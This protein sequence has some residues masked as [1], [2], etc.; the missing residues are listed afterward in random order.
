MRLLSFFF[1]GFILAGF[2]ALLGDM[3]VLA[4]T[5]DGAKAEPLACTAETEGIATC[6]AGKVCE[7]IYVPAAAG[8]MIAA[9]EKTGKLP[10][11]LEELGIDAEQRLDD[12]IKNATQLIEPMM[13][14]VMGGVIGSVAIAL[15]LP[16]FT[17]SNVLSH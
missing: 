5:E 2:F 1:A 8:Q 14:L 12:S 15:L 9:A 16:I 17:I 3:A 7:C 6:Y 11:V 4:Q 13:I 10:E